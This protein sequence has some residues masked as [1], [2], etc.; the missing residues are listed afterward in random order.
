MRRALPTAFAL[1]SLSN[2]LAYLFGPALAGTVS[3][4]LAPAGV[5]LAATSILVGCLALARQRPRRERL[6]GAATR[7]L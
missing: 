5:A 1:E 6:T 4:A 7:F 3:A 2:E